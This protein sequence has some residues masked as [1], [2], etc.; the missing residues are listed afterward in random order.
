MRV[1]F[2]PAAFMPR[3]KKTSSQPKRKT[4]KTIVIPEK[5]Y[6]L[7]IEEFKKELSSKT[8]FFLKIDELELFK[9]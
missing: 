5:I 6:P 3:I 9:K 2:P 8:P 4:K 1:R 7:F